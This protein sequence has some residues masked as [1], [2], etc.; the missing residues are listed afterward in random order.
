MY[1][2]IELNKKLL[3]DLREIAKELNVKRVESFRKQDLIYKILDTQAVVVSE[4]KAARK[5]TKNQDRE[6]VQQ[7]APQ[8]ENRRRGRPKMKKER[9]QQARPEQTQETAVQA[10]PVVRETET[11]T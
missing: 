5:D 3:S 9:P 10:E 8:N 7:G 1:D 11:K 2:I 4:A 6:K